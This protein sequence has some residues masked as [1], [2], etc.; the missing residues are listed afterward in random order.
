MTAGEPAAAP[1]APD[2]PPLV[3]AGP[4]Q[5]AVADDDLRRRFVE[6]EVPDGRWVPITVPSHWRTNPDLGPVAGSVLH[7]TRFDLDDGADPAGTRRW[8]VLDGVIATSDVWLDGAYLGDTEGYFFPHAFEI[9]DLCLQR[10]D[11][12]LALDVACRAEEDR[13]RKRNL[14]GALQD[15]DLLPHDLDPGGIWRPVRVERSGPVRITHLRTLCRDATDES[16]TVFVR[17]V[18]DA[19]DSLA[20][21]L[22]TTLVPLDADGRPR[23]GAGVDHRQTRTL[24]QGENRVEWTVAVPEPRRWWPH[25]L[26]PPDRYELRI[27]VHLDDEPER[28][29]SDVR[30]RTIGLRSVAADDF[31]FT[32]NGE[33]L[34]LKGTNLAP[35]DA[36][37]AGV[38]AERFVHDVQAAVDAHLDLVRVHSHVSRPEL[39]DAADAAGLLLWQDLPLHRGYHRSVRGQAR[40]QA[41]ELVDLLGHHPSIAVWCGHDEPFAVDGRPDTTPTGPPRRRVARRLAIAQQLPSWNKTVLDRTIASVLDTCDGSRPVI[42]HSGVLPHPLTFTGT[43]SHLRVGWAG[44]EPGDLAARL[45]RWPR[46]ARFVSLAGTPSVADPGPEPAPEFESAQA[47]QAELVRRQ[48]EALRRLKYRPTGGFLHSVLADPRPAASPAVIGHDRVPKPAYDALRGACAP[49]IVVAD[50]FPGHVARG[51]PI[52]LAVH[53]I[54]DRHISLDDMMVEAYLQEGEDAEPERSHPG[55]GDGARRRWRWHGELTADSCSFVGRV[56]TTAP[57]APGR[58]LLELV[59][60][61][62]RGVVATNRYATTVGRGPG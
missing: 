35:T 58:L 2:G 51:A 49:V 48:V 18:L 50:P 55:S 10:D 33:R 25:A 38:P 43:D 9:T 19:P 26:G 29:P 13:T 3:L 28:G 54:N 52:D 12:L 7:R 24:A 20:V 36:D 5:A 60:R 62:A 22:V 34:F 56:R 44:G 11:H 40:R 42:T 15:S 6:P 1:W 32:V 41:R 57:S 37:L 27:E 39:Y 14:T 21:E 45:R 61:D 23:S 46:L 16:A 59:L 4:W 53:V 30:T 47:R 31:V 8:L 17:A